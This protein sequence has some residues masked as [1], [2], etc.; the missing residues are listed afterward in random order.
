L[1]LVSE[2]LVSDLPF[3]VDLPNK[4]RT[5]CNEWQ[6]TKGETTMAKCRVVCPT[7]GS[8][9]PVDVEK[10]EIL[11]KKLV[12][13]LKELAYAPPVFDDERI[14]WVNIQVPKALLQEAWD[15]LKLLD[16]GSDDD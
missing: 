8:R 2:K 9:V 11:I 16:N 13:L 12:E 14:R 5:I 15:L 10:Q 6:T 7:C 3:I 4:I 1:P